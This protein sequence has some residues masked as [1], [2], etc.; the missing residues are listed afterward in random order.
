MEEREQRF[1]QEAQQHQ[2]Q[3]E[4]QLREQQQMMSWFM[5]QAILTSPPGSLPTP[6]FPFSWVSG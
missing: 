5:N 6:P 4:Q 1:Q 2:A 3:L